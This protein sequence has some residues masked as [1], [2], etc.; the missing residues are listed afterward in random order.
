MGNRGF[1]HADRAVTEALL[2]VGGYL[3]GS[4]PFG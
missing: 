2:V 3:A 1:L 4:L